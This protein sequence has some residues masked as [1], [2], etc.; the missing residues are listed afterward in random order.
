MVEREITTNIKEFHSRTLERITSEL[1]NCDIINAAL[2]IDEF[3]S[4]LQFDVERRNITSIEYKNFRNDIRKQ[5]H[6][7]KSRCVCSSK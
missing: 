7:A 6:M 4:S 2:D 3:S 5:L 1:K